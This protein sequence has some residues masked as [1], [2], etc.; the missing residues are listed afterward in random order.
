M[1]GNKGK[2]IQFYS[3]GMKQR[4]KLALAILSESEM[5]ILDEPT[6]NLDREGKDWYQQMIKSNIGK[7]TLVIA[8]ND[9]E[10][11]QMV[12]REVSVDQSSN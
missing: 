1:K 11:Y 4:V 10:E 8:S 12:D 9:P 2:Q 6:S 5:V 7:R 3:S